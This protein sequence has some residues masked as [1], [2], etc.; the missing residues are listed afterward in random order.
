MAFPMPAIS[1]LRAM[2]TPTRPPIARVLLAELA[3]KP[4][5]RRTLG[6][7]EEREVFV[8]QRDRGANVPDAHADDRRPDPFNDVGET[9]RGN[10]LDLHGFRERRGRTDEVERPT[11]QRAA[12]DQRQRGTAKYDGAEG[13]SETERS[14]LTGHNFLSPSKCQQPMAKRRRHESHGREYGPRE[15]TVGFRQD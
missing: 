8:V 2:T 12:T 4:F 14:L 9:E 3:E 6:K 10:A 7:V 5:H 11:D 1:A 15:V 13:T